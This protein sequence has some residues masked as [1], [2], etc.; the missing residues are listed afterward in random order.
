MYCDLTWWIYLLTAVISLY[1]TGLFLWWS[2]LNGF[3]SSSVFVYTL[4]WLAGTFIISGVNLYARSLR[5]IDPRLFYDFSQTIWW[6]ARN[7]VV[8]AVLIILCV[9]MSARACFWAQ[10]KNGIPHNRRSDD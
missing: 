1:G 2:W 5:F 4:L 8:L 7:L 9:H 6:P 10:H 3:R